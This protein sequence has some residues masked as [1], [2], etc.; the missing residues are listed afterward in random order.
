MSNLPLPPAASA[1]D[2]A[3]NKAITE[4]ND[5]A[6][7]AAVQTMLDS[8]NIGAGFQR[9]YINKP[10]D[11]FGNEGTGNTWLHIAVLNGYP[12]AIKKLLSLKADP[13]IKNSAGMTPVDLAT[14]KGPIHLLP[15]FLEAAHAKK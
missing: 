2:I 8:S 3:F 13:T 11:F 12:Y 4:R 7:D 6:L 5:R 1:A 10:I 9:N 15:I 14:E